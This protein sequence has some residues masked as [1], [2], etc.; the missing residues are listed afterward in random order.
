MK[1]SV[2]IP[3]YNAEKYVEQTIRSL[4]AQTRPPAEIIVVDDGSTD[5]SLEIVKSFGERVEV[6]SSKNGSAAVTR[7]QGYAR[8]TGD[9]VMFLDADDVLAPDALEALSEVPEFMDGGVG[10]CPWRRLEL[11]NGRWIHLPPSCAERQRGE[12]PLKAWLRGWYHPTSTVLWSRES[13]E[14]L[15]GWNREAGVNDDGDLMMRALALGVP[16]GIATR[17]SVFYR[18]LPE[19]GLSLSGKRLSHAGLASR[20]WTV[21]NLASLLEWTGQ[22]GQYRGAL[23]GAARAILRDCGSEH[24]DLAKRVGD[25]CSRIGDSEWRHKVRSATGRL[26]SGV[27]KL[28]FPR[29]GSS[30]PEPPVEIRFGIETEL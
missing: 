17:G 26:R 4:L 6:V 30:D 23:S 28:R 2:I 22:L 24:P 9:A 15:G 21:E 7:N 3:C 14:R 11:H 5:R 20:L 10:C 13:Y 8:S 19:S 16:F 25:L 27:R 29:D 12:D 1:T 18:R